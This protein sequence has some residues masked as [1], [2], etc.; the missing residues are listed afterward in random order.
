MVFEQLVAEAAMKK[1]KE[2]KKKGKDKEK[3]K[4]KS[5]DQNSNHSGAKFGDKAWTAAAEAV[6]NDA[7]NV[8]KSGA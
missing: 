1:E 6:A 3:D 7:P 5:T 8:P 4:R 2:S